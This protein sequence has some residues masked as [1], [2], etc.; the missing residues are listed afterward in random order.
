MNTDHSRPDHEN[1]EREAVKTAS[2]RQFLSMGGLFAGTLLA[3]GIATRALAA[4]CGLTPR[5]AKGPFYPENGIEP[6]NDLT[7]IPGAPRPARGQLIYV[8]GK[9]T[10]ENCRPVANVN[11]EIWQACESGRYNHSQ[12]PN[13]QARLDPNF[14]YWGET[15]TDER[16][17][18]RFKSILPGAYPADENWMRPP[19]IHFRVAK[20]GYQELITQ[21]YFKGDRLNPQDRILQSLPPEEQ[22]K[23]V[24]DFRPSAAPFDPRGLTGSFDISIRSVPA[25]R[26]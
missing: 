26:R 8:I 9:V 17:E 23:V 25:L 1:E 11:V 14:A 3:G 19:H 18:Y 20:T 2:R 4:T 10:D 13:R 5:Q 24:V 6:G 22:A 16:G 7:Q 21:M 15:F 12:D